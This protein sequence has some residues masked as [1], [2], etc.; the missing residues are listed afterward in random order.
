M[1]TATPVSTS[2]SPFVQRRHPRRSDDV[3]R[4]DPRLVGLLVGQLELALPLGLDPAQVVVDLVVDG[5]PSSQPSSPAISSA[6]GRG[7]GDAAVEG[8][9]GD[10]GTPGQHVVE[11]PRALVGDRVDDLGGAGSPRRPASGSPSVGPLGR[12]GRA[13]RR[14]GRRTAPA[15]GRSA[16]MCRPTRASERTR[17]LVRA[18]KPSAP[19]QRHPLGDRVARRR[20]ARRSECAAASTASRAITRYVV[21]LAA[22]DHHQAGHRGRRRCARARCGWS[23]SRLARASSGRSPAYT[24]S[25]SSWSS[26]SRRIAL[27]WLEQVVDVGR[28]GRRVRLVEVPRRCRW[29]R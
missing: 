22:G 8:L 6:A 29:C 16:P 19:D 11:V 15:G 18:S 13:P 17:W 7:A 20:P 3:G 5:R 26:G 28:A 10:A 25:T 1:V 4:A 9:D 14:R 23:G 12:S 2:G 24:P 27:T 21:Q